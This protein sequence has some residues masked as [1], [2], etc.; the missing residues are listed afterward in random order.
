MCTNL[1]SLAGKSLEPHSR[2]ACGVENVKGRTFF[3]IQHNAAALISL[4]LPCDALTLARHGLKHPALY[5]ISEPSSK[6]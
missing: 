1:H 3:S 4:Q 6:P 2:G 5:H